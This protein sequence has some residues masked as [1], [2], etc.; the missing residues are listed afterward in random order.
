MHYWRHPPASG[1]P[2]L[3]AMRAMGLRL[4]DI[5]V[6]WGVHETAPGAT[7][8]ASAT[9]PSTSRAF[10]SSRTRSAC[11]ACCGRGRTS[12]RS[13]RS[14]GFPSASCGTSSA[15]RAR[16]AATPSSC[17]SCPW[18]S[19]FRA[20]RATRSS[21]RRRTGT[22]RSARRWGTCDG[23][24]GPIVL[25]QV[26][27][28][29]ALY[30]RDGSTT[31][32]PPGRGARVSRVS[33]R[34]VS[35]EPARAAIAWQDQTLAFATVDPPRRFDARE[36]RDLARHVDWAEFHEELLSTAMERMA[37]ALVDAGLDGVPRPTTCRS[38]RARRPSTPRG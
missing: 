23:P 12:T 38:A 10:S 11:G 14:S 32:L 6:P 26:D 16:R 17:P 18:P 19:R 31:G 1:A 20:T 27:N 5:Y 36:T 28:E 24:R 13:S 35:Q 22:A 2:C 33:A 29:G 9:R 7:T 4:V 21:R 25:L 37:A 34:Q 15:R 30:F 3:E 8:S